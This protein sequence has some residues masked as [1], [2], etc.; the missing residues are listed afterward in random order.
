[1]L[2]STIYISSPKTHNKEAV[3]KI[4]IVYDN[5]VYKEG[6]RSDWGFSCLV[7]LSREEAPVILFDT[8][9]DGSI[10]LYN[11]DK[12]GIDPASVD[13]IFISHAHFDHTGGLS[14]FLGVNPHVTLYLPRSMEGIRGPEK[15]IFVDKSMKIHEEVF[16]TG[17]LE[18]I[19]QSM[20]VRTDKGIAVITGCSHPRMEHILDAASQF[21]NLYAVI[22]GLHGFHEYELFKDL[23]LIC[24]T[25]CTMHKNEIKKRYPEKYI[26]AGAGR[27]IEI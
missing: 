24:P 9:T 4:T 17:E 5:T 2:F 3:M 7:E 6:L 19:E 18:H 25:H 20:A 14:G 11:M 15:V 27:V 16:S 13:E 21:G 26:E 22:G 8:G 12:L 1:M 10:L 23:A